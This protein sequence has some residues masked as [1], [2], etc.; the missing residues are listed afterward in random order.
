MLHQSPGFH[1]SLVLWKYDNWFRYAETSHY[2]GS[3]FSIA[4]KEVSYGRLLIVRMFRTFPAVLDNAADLGLPR[5]L[6]Q[7]T[8]EEEMMKDAGTVEPITYMHSVS[9]GDRYSQA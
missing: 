4:Y 8:E 3:M 1:G 6:T 9:V 5:P 2:L 7:L